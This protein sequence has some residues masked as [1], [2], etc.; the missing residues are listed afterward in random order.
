MAL[1]YVTGVWTAGECMA[2][3]RQ[4][5]REYAG[6]STAREF[7]YP[8]NGSRLRLKP[9]TPIALNYV[10]AQGFSPKR[11]TAQQLKVSDSIGTIHARTVQLPFLGIWVCA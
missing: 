2:N 10:E 1:D 9:K 8:K 5:K 3:W 4:V 11:C 6:R 7:N